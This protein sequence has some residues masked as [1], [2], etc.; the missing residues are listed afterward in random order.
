SSS[1]RAWVNLRFGELCHRARGRCNGADESA[2]KRVAILQIRS[3]RFRSLFY[4][5]LCPET[6]SL[7]GRHALPVE[8]GRHDDRGLRA[9]DALQRADAVD[10][11]IELGNRAGR[12]HGHQVDLAADRMQR[13]NL[14]YV[15]EFGDGR[16]GMP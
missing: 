12:D 13:A 4:A 6:G 14:P 2:R 15:L 10:D 11:G 5:P 9:F 3:M 1:W 8:L 7:F 16:H